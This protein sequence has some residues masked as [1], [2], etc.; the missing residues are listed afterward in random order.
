MPA[1]LLSTVSSLET[2]ANRRRDRR[3]IPHNFGFLAL[4]LPYLPER[5]APIGRVCP[6]EMGT[7][8]RLSATKVSAADTTAET[9]IKRMRGNDE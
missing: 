4:M 2:M 5:L 8:S 9:R 3:K 6:Q 7:G 1:S